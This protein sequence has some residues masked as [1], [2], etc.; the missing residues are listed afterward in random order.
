L[1]DDH[2]GIR[3]SIRKLLKITGDIQVIGEASNGQ[4]ALQLSR[5]LTPDVLLLDMEMPGLTG[6][7]VARQLQNGE[8]TISIL[9][10]SGYDDWSYIQGFLEVGA[11]GYLVKAEAPEMIVDAVRGVAQ[12]EYGW[13]SLEVTRSM[14]APTWNG[15]PEEPM[16]LTGR[17]KAVLKL[18]AAGKSNREIGRRLEL[19]Q[20]RVETYQQTASAK[21]GTGSGPAAAVL[22]RQKGLI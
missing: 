13:V 19:N 6:L 15:P 16:P 1:A 9:A 14:P 5:E 17:E 7:E 8:S 4:E 18:V 22:A 21:L 3:A 2:P 10:I 12:G 11:A 20:K